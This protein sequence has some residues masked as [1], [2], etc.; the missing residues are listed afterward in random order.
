MRHSIVIVLLAA[1]AA[2]H[3]TPTWAANGDIL[4]RTAIPA[5]ADASFVAEACVNS[6]GS[7]GRTLPS[8][9]RFV[10][11]GQNLARQVDGVRGKSC[12]IRAPN[13]RVCR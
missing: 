1:V 12:R 11:A 5:E 4:E 3:C 9:P 2:F 7:K 10:G 8:R 13:S 6:A